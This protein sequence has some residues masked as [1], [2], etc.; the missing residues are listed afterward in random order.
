MLSLSSIFEPQS[1]AVVG[2]SNNETK[3]GGRI[4]K[5]LLSNFKGRVYPVNPNEKTVQGMTAYPSISDIPESIEMAVI[6]IPSKFVLP[7][8]EECGQKGV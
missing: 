4:L 3:W 5:N 6:T 2:A 8:V 1:I 7:V